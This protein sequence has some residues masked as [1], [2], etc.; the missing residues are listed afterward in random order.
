MREDPVPAVRAKALDPD[1]RLVVL[2]EEQWHHIT[3]EHP[4]M[5]RFE[6]AIMETLTHPSHRDR[7]VRPG[8]ER[9][10][11]ERRGPTRWLRVVVD[12]SNEPGFVVTAFG[13]DEEP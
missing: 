5:A 6:R 10:F 7:D 4:E 8:R 9:F 12:Y 11:A 13:Q 3:A 1:G 2:Q